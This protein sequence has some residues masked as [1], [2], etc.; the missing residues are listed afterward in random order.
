MND[1]NITANLNKIREIYNKYNAYFSKDK[2]FKDKIQFAIRSVL[3][4]E[5]LEG[6]TDPKIKD[7]IAFMIPLMEHI[8]PIMGPAFKGAGYT[9]D[10][11]AKFHDL[12]VKLSG[13]QH[14]RGGGTEQE[15]RNGQAQAKTL[16]SIPVTL[17][18]SIIIASFTFPAVIGIVI[19]PIIWFIVLK[20]RQSI[21]K[22]RNPELYS[23]K[24]LTNVRAANVMVAVA[25]PLPVPAYGPSI[26]VAPT[27]VG[28]SLLE[29]LAAISGSMY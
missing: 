29:L 21:N 15:R 14:I 16:I 25:S 2:D 4:T 11:P 19:I 13:A 3:E 26:P 28:S 23:P 1:N 12:A 7:I 22:K 17:V 18:V 8:L 9:P 24:D 6:I 27:G 10:L 5:S 20:T